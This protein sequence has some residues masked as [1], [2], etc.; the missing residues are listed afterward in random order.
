MAHMAC[1]LLHYLY[2]YLWRMPMQL[3]TA[4]VSREET[5]Y[6]GQWESEGNA[7]YTLKF[8]SCVYILLFKNKWY[9]KVIQLLWTECLRPP[10]IYMLKPK[11]LM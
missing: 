5:G 7:L 4:L 9:T 10:R 2:G 3:V 6:L 11:S 8:L 1:Q